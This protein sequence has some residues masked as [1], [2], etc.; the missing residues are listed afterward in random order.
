FGITERITVNGTESFFLLPL[1]FVVVTALFTLLGQNLGR[2]LTTVRPPLTAYSIDIAGAI[3]GSA[4]FVLV[5]LLGAQPGVWFGIAAVAVLLLPQRGGPVRLLNAGILIGIVVW[6]SVLGRTS[7]W[8]PY[9]RIDVQRYPGPSYELFVNNIG[10]Q[11]MGPYARIAHNFYYAAPFETFRFPASARELIVGSGT[12]S[13]V[14]VALHRGIRHIT[15][16]ELDPAIYDL[17]RRL[18]PDHVYQSRAVRA[19][20][21]DGRSFLETTNG[22]YDLIVFALPDSLAL[23]SSFANV[24]LE[25]Y[26]F[27]R[28]AF[29][30]VR[31]HLSANG[32]FVLYNDYRTVWLMRK[33]AGMLTDVFGEAPYAHLRWIRRPA[34]VITAVL[35]D[36]PRLRELSPSAYAG[37]RVTGDPGVTPATDDWPFVY[38]KNRTVPAIYLQAIGLTWLIA[39]AAI[40]LSLRLGGEGLRAGLRRFDLALFFMGLAFLLLEAKSIVNFTLL[41]G[42]T[43]LVNALVIIGILCTVLLANWVNAITRLRLD[44][45]LLYACLAATLLVNLVL[46]F[47]RLLVSD[48]A[49]RYVLGCA[50]LFSPILMA[51]LIFGRLFGATDIPDVAFASNL[52]GAFIGGTLEYASLQIGYHLLLLPVLAAYGVSFLVV[53]QRRGWSGLVRGHP[54]PDRLVGAPEAAAG[55][56]R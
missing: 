8:S 47:N 26:L 21:D 50:V 53:A 3:A 14:D 49:L 4:V 2:L 43:W 9:Y 13:D 45:R 23:T 38:L 33:I 17:G 28:E 24:R 36:G 1:V 7:D 46:P 6:V 34:P 10:H 27:T 29:A 42:A 44:L 35:M 19:V 20:I 56:R 31:R 11:A 41:F 40:G 15:A 55:Q 30:Q 39:L 54:T 52:L 25:S 37:H 22:R 18:N 16:V 51:N 12:G 32:V 5:S 48:L